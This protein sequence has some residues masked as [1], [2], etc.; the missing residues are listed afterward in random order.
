MSFPKIASHFETQLVNKIDST[1]TTMVLASIATPAGNLGAGTYGFVIDEESGSKREYCIGT[2]S[3]STVTFT[4]RDVSPLDATT[5]DASADTARQSHRKGASVKI[6]DFPLL[7]LIQRVLEGTDQLDPATPL[8]YS[9]SASIS[10]ANQLATKEYVDSVVNGGTLIL[11]DR[12]ELGDAGETI[13]DGEYVY[14]KESDGEWYKVDAD[15]L[16]TLNGVKKGIAQGAG[17]DGNAI[18]GGILVQ[19]LDTTISYTTGQLYYASNT[20]GG[21]STTAGTNTHVIGVGDANNKLVMFLCDRYTPTY[22]Q[23]KFLDGVTGMVIPFAG[24]SAPT[25][26]LLCD[27]SAVSRTTYVNLFT[28][29]GTTYGVGDGSTT[30]N[31][32]NLK[33]KV[34]VGYNS[35]ETEFDAM[36]ETGGAKTHTLTEAEIPAHD[37]GLWGNVTI[38]GI[39]EDVSGWSS[40]SA[41]RFNRDVTQEAGG[42]GAHNNLQPYLVM[43]YIIKT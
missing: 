36:G 17:T 12:V 41:S 22:E 10:N 33:G 9:G 20:A 6:T 15:N 34:I 39:D 32:P 42:G 24:S 8:Q 30:F 26:F 27:G 13:A 23:K 40:A 28:L 5:E 1:S 18:S 16:A 29:I 11:Q 3:G 21:I 25:G 14:L 2:L 7:L 37:H 35:A 4:K 43:Q 38:S 31:V 19:G